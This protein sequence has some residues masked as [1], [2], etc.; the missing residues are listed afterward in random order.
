MVWDAFKAYIHGIFIAFKV[1][2]DKTRREIRLNVLSQIQRLEKE[3]MRNPTPENM[4]RLSE[5][6]K[7][8]KLLD[9][10]SID[11]KVFIHKQHQFAFRNK[12]GK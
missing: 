4:N 2:K 8:L 1:Y 12:P 11:K 7:K 6:Y 10:K 3:V 9:V 5:A